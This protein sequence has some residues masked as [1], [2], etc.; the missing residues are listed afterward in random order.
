MGAWLCLKVL[1][2]ARKVRPEDLGCLQEKGDTLRRGVGLTSAQGKSVVPPWQH[3]RHLLQA[4]LAN[5]LKAAVLWC[6]LR[7]IAVLHPLW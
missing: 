4:A 7:C 2:G 3:E 5:L 6:A 1:F